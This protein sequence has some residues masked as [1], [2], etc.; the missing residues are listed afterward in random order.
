MSL[1]GCRALIAAVAGSVVVYLV[2]GVAVW[3]WWPVITNWLVAIAQNLAASLIWGV[4][5]FVHLHVRLNRDH[6]RIR[7][8]LGGKQVD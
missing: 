4:P 7:A 2:I 8:E 5:A 6:A 1:N 3:R